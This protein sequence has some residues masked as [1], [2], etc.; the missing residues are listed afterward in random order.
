MV[1]L[2][3]SRLLVYDHLISVTLLADGNVFV[4][5]VQHLPATLLGCL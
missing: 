3:D 5:C 1:S 4:V 2:L